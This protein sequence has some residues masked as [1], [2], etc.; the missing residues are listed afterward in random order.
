MSVAKVSYTKLRR[1]L[2]NSNPLQT[3][4]HKFLPLITYSIKQ[5]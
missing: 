2:S 3:D 1:N 4:L 5:K